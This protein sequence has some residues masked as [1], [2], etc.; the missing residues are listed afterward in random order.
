M[1]TSIEVLRWTDSSTEILNRREDWNWK[2]F[3]CLQK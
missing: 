3:S 2:I 1:D